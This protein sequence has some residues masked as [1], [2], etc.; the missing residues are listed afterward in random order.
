MW[1]AAGKM[2]EWTVRL[3][4]IAVDPSP[5]SPQVPAGSIAQA[6]ETGLAAACA[7]HFPSLSDGDQVLMELLIKRGLL[8]VDQ[9]HTAHVYCDEHKRDLRQTILELN[10]ISP[11]LLNQLAF[12]R[13]SALALDNGDPQRSVAVAAAAGPLSPNRT[14]HQR[15]V[16]KELQEK[17]QTATMSELVSQILERACDCEATDIHFDPQESGLRVRLPDR[18][19]ASGHP[20]RRAG[21]G[22]AG[23]QPAQDPLEPEH[24]RAKALAGRPDHDSAQSPARATCEWRRFPRFSA[25]RSSSG[26][27]R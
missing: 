7:A 16:R 17:A 15:D 1:F 19:A 9:A 10:L 18:W 22:D 13:L 11:D 2:G 4:G 24:R 21:D 8:S 6:R 27:T 23:G 12:E 3:G 5:T 25:R 26:S 14:Q 20:V